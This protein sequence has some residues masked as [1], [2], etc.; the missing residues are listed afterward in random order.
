[1]C[2]INIL[3]YRTIGSVASVMQIGSLNLSEDSRP[4][5]SVTNISANYLAA[6]EILC[7]AI[8]HSIWARS[9]L[10]SG[11]RVSDGVK[12]WAKTHPEHYYRI[13]IL[14]ALK[15]KD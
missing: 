7:M 12:E 4:K 15:A 8:I 6:Q 11:T 3:K 10:M 9:T 2:G 5:S 1:M 13:G 14:G